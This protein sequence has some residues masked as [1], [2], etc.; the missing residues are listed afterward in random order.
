MLDITGKTN[1]N[2]RERK[3]GIERVTKSRVVR[4]NRDFPGV[5]DCKKSA[6]NPGDVGSIL[7][8]LDPLKKEMVTHSNIL[9]WRIPWTEE[10]GS[11]L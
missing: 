8:W 3:T 10:P 5:S 9:A 7:G 11:R 4:N 1:N 6:F 2:L